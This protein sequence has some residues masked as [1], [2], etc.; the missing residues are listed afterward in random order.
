[1]ADDDTERRRHPRTGQF[2]QSLT[3]IYRGS[4]SDWLPLSRC[5]SLVVYQAVEGGPLFAT[6]HPRWIG[7]ERV[8]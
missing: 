7:W 3:V 8:P 5:A 4:G 6:D 2:Y 1:M